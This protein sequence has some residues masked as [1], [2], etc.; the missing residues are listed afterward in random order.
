[1]TD[2]ESEVIGNVISRLILS[3]YEEVPMHLPNRRA[4]AQHLVM[5][6]VREWLDRPG[7]LDLE[8]EQQ[9]Y[10]TLH[11]LVQEIVMRLTPVPV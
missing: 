4:L 3:T 9:L 8:S 10:R 5:E 11:R 2:G 7:T 6:A 1:M